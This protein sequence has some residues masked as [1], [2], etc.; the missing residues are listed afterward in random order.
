MTW[1]ACVT[2]SSLNCWNSV[3]KGERTE[4]SIQMP[5]LS[6]LIAYNFNHLFVTNQSLYIYLQ[7]IYI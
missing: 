1:V 2:S 3:F 6:V 7:I 4:A 5:Y